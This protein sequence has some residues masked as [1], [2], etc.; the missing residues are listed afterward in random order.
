MQEAMLAEEASRLNRSATAEQVKV[1][2]NHFDANLSEL[3]RA[4]P[5][6][7]SSARRGVPWAP[8]PMV[9]TTLGVPQVEK[10]TGD[11]VFRPSA[12]SATSGQTAADDD[13][14]FKAK[15]GKSRRRR[16]QPT[17]PQLL[18]LPTIPDRGGNGA[19]FRPKPQAASQP[20][21]Q[22][23]SPLAQAPS[24]AQPAPPH[25]KHRELVAQFRDFVLVE[26]SAVLDAFRLWDA[27]LSESIS[28]SEFR[29]ALLCT[30]ISDQAEVA[31]LWKRLDTDGNGEMAYDEFL[32]ALSPKMK[33]A[34][35]GDVLSERLHRTMVDIATARVYE[36]FKTFDTKAP[37]GTLS[38]SEFAKAIAV[39]GMKLKRAELFQ[40]FDDMDEDKSNA[41]DYN[42]L[43]MALEVE[44]APAEGGAHHRRLPNSGRAKLSLDPLRPLAGQISD[45]LRDQVKGVVD[46]FQEW[47]AD[48]SNGISFSEFQ[49]AMGSVGLKPSEKIRNLWAEINTDSDGV[50]TYEELQL[51]FDPPKLAIAPKAYAPQ[52]VSREAVAS[53]LRAKVTSEIRTAAT[54]LHEAFEDL[55][56]DRAL[57]V[58]KAWDMD[59][60]GQ[61]TAA[62]FGKAMAAL[63]I[64]ATKT[65]VFKL[66]KQ[67]DSSSNQTL[68]YAEL[69]KAIK[70]ERVQSRGARDFGG[71]GTGMY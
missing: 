2:L 67:M 37:F 15:R 12:R 19:A 62:E 38:R 51:A 34:N 26:M 31:S 33:A 71:F 22:P 61:I 21:P 18:P 7:S 23:A 55:A 30:G 57:D 27:D 6:L 59:G 17:G 53:E 46:T 45:L 68:E 13:D 10:Q 58:F 66:F 25:Y 49:G 70:A 14:V 28:F 47:D 11:G 35:Q 60:D 64:K 1:E 50:I 56:T 3:Q 39:L 52:A 43:R 32:A 29:R 54:Q 9:D 16:T 4:R 48:G 24:A 42:E 36:I 63:G 5:R 20:A 44:D 40:L 69:Y 65:E 8:P 41:I